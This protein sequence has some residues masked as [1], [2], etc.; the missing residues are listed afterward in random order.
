MTQLWLATGNEKKQKELERLLL[1]LGITVEAHSLGTPETAH[2][3]AGN[4]LLK[5]KALARHQKAFALGDDSGLCVDGLDGRP[6]VHSARYAGPRATDKDRIERLLKDLAGLAN[7]RR[8]ARFVCAICLC[9]P[10]GERIAAFD[11]VCDGMVLT[12]PRGE[13]GFGYDPLFVP[14]EFPT[15]TF[16]ELPAADKDR[17]SHRGKALRKLLDYLQKHPLEP[18][19]AK[20]A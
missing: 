12:Q 14:R 19:A 5:A 6:G 4:A 2:D 13:G 20:P 3:F 10:R 17:I 11:A 8:T 16:A 15:M 1:P 9:D 7:E 18:V